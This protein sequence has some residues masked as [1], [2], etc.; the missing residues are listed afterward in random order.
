VFDGF[1]QLDDVYRTILVVA[2]A[3]VPV[4]PSAPPTFRLYG[5]DGLMPDFTDVPMSAIDE[6]DDVHSWTCDI[7]CTASAFTA[8][9]TYHMVIRSVVGDDPLIDQ[10]SFTVT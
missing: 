9:G 5:P 3:G 2:Q 10:R 6:V 8:G 1:V 4:E 7:D